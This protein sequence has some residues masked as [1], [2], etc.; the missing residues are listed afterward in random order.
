MKRIVSSLAFATGMLA[1]SAFAAT[2]TYSAIATGPAEAVPVASPGFSFATIVV[3]DTANTLSVSSPFQYLLGNSTMAHIHAGTAE[4]LLGTA[5]VALPFMD[6][7]TGVKSGDY[8]KTFNLLDATVYGADFLSANGGSVMGARDALLE[9]ISENRAY[10]NIHSNLYPAGE[11]RG[12]LIA[13]PVPEPSAYAMLAVGLAG[14]GVV[15][16]RKQKAKEVA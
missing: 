13:A 7:P 5:P 1:S 12:F 10:L 16:R 15:A 14:V 3:D 4:P 6:F 11:I 2:T 8:S 9:D